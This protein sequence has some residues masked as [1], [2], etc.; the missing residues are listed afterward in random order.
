MQNEGGVQIVGIIE[1]QHPDRCRLFMQWKEMEWPILV[2]SLNRLEVSSVPITL[3]IDEHGIVR[4]IRPQTSD[5]HDFLEKEFE[6][7]DRWE[8]ANTAI[9][10]LT[11]LK[12]GAQRGSAESLRTLGDAIV[13]WEG[14]AVIGQAIEAYQMAL[15]KDGDVGPTHFRLGVAYRKRYDSEYRQDKDFTR[16]VEHWAKALEIDPNQYIHRRRIQQYG[17]R[18]DKPYPF[19]DWISRA[20]EEIRAR[21]DIPADIIVEPTGAEVASPLGTDVDTVAGDE[22]PDPRGR[23]IRDRGRF[24]KIEKIFVPSTEDSAHAAR[25]HLVFRPNA[26]I[27]AHWNNEVDGLVF[28]INP[29]EG[30]TVSRRY[31]ELPNP[32]QSVSQETRT[33]ELEIGWPERVANRST[34]WDGYA[35]YYVCEDVDGTCLYRR[36]DVSLVSSLK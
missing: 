8:Q 23:I 18:L 20:R 34:S 26:V 1:E 27:K 17:P 6:P 2:D 36:Q 21:G 5:L 28:W 3:L 25:V 19:Y 35:L 4:K 10:N 12:E 33:I 24:V 30:W 31:H 9:P 14:P 16:A 13:E 29:P 11:Q 22:E 7:P 15:G 32:R